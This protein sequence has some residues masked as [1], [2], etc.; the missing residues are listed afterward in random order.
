MLYNEL[1]VE[2]LLYSLQLFKTREKLVKS[3][4]GYCYQVILG[5]ED[6]VLKN[7]SK[8]M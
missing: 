2:L 3:H 5:L 6:F 7:C 1:K 4:L 8:Q